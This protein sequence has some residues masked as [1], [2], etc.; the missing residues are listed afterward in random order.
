MTSLVRLAR[1]PGVARVTAS[2]I[3]ARFPLGMLS[4]GL[5]M[6]VRTVTGS[7]ALAG[8]AVAV[9]SVGEGVAGPLAGRLLGRFGALPVIGIATVLCAIVITV[10]A[11]GVDG[12][13]TV[14]LCGLGGLTVP[15]VA[16]AVR[17]F[18]PSLVPSTMLAAL[19]SID[20]SAQEVIWTLGP[21]L[22]TVLAGAASASVALF[23]AAGMLVAGGVWFLTASRGGASR[24]GP[25]A[26]PSRRFGRSL[27]SRP[28]IAAT[29]TSALLVASYAALEVAVLDHFGSDPGRT[30]IAIAASSIGSLAGGL[31]FGARIRSTTALTVAIASVFAFTA[32]A[33]LVSG[34]PLFLAS[35]F[36]SGLGF[37]PATAYLSV[38]VSESARPDE[39]GEAFGWVTTGSLMGAASGTAL[40]GFA[41]EGTG[42]TGAFLLASTTAAAATVVPLVLLSRRNRRAH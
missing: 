2:Q 35:M 13:A 15:P 16:Q 4:L 1:H 26:A 25:R 3:L 23:T 11:I 31:L 14:V 12:P 38:L 34:V 28:V 19:F 39:S 6:H 42:A 29:V 10:I 7:Y 37:A 30:G 32:I 17:A 36:L 41:A 21:L 24:P 8:A 20:A 22:A 9:W 5:L 18:Y 40:A 27:L 33:A